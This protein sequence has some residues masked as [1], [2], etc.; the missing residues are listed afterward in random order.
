MLVATERRRSKPSRPR[1]ARLRSV[2][3]AIALTAVS[4][5]WVATQIQTECEAV[6]RQALLGYTDALNSGEPTL[7]EQFIADSGSF[8]WYSENPSRVGAEARDRESLDDYLSSRVEQD[9]RLRVLFFDFNA[10]APVGVLGQFGFYAINESWDF[11]TGKGAVSC[12]TGELTVLSI[13][14]AKSP[15]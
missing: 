11:M 2:A 15:E 6:T 9:A 13:G 7:V 12:E 4:G 5:F 1:F 3:V 10:E 8:S 14:G